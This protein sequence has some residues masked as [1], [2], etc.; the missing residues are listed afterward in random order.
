[1]RAVPLALTEDRAAVLALAGDLAPDLTGTLDE[2][3]SEVP[4]GT[5][6]RLVP[7]PHP[8]GVAALAVRGS[9]RA[10]P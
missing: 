8:T 5:L 3:L 6:Q 2:L 9:G 4:A 10:V 1:M 7:R